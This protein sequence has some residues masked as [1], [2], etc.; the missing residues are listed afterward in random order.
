[1][2]VLVLVLG[3]VVVVIGVRVRGV[4]PSWSA[5]GRAPAVLVLA[6]LAV[7]VC[8]SA[9]R[10]WPGA[11]AH[12]PRAMAHRPGTGKWLDLASKPNRPRIVAQGVEL[13]R[14]DRAHR[15]APLADEVLAA[16][17][18]GGRVEA[19]PV[20]EVHVADEPELLEDLQV[21]IGRGDVAGARGSRGRRAREPLGR[22]RALA[23]E[24]RLEQQPPSGGEP[25]AG[26]ANHGARLLGVGH[27]GGGDV[28]RN[29]HRRLTARPRSRAASRSSA[30][31]RCR[32]AR[33]RARL[34]R[35]PRRRRR[36][37]SRRS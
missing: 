12:R 36:S 29:R 22:D 13:G 9:P 28:R 8:I 25:Q 31:R 15:R 27:V 1:M 16:G 20:A 5:R 18:G 6:V 37:R 26:G 2:A 23:R 33:R 21:A 30:P 4:S 10:S 24:Q 3:V 19:R 7:V 11:L 14:L 17:M 32:G 35:S 34:P